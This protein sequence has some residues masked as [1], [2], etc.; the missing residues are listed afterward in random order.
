[1]GNRLPQPSATS[2]V[3]LVSLEGVETYLPCNGVPGTGLGSA[4]NLRL[5]S[6]ASW[7]FACA[8]PAGSFETLA[9]NVAQT[10][11]LLQMPPGQP[12][13]TEQQNPA[14]HALVTQALTSG[15]VPLNYTTRQGEQTVAWY[16]G[17]FSP[18]PTQRDLTRAPYRCVEDAMLYD[19]NTGMFDQSYAV[20]WQIGRLLALADNRFSTALL[21]WRQGS[22]SATESLNGRLQLAAFA[23]PHL[24]A[25]ETV[26]ELAQP[27]V[28]HRMVATFLHQELSPRIAPE[29][30]SDPM[31]PIVPALHPAP[32]P[33]GGATASTATVADGS[34]AALRPH[35]TLHALLEWVAE[36]IHRHRSNEPEG[37]DA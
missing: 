1:F 9:Q 25:P 31:I 19:P 24:T 11:G 22:F 16:R 30:A 28:P 6:L 3:H 35:P 14:V 27:R 20:A 12:G 29:D 32:H 2:I 4:T 5:F 18:I 37:E 13:P 21:Q 26:A 36:H 33:E 8:D 15:Y 10:A 17:P 34:E 7:T 23:A